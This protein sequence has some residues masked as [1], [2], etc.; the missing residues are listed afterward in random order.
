MCLASGERGALY[1]AARAVW[2]WWNRMEIDGDWM[3]KHRFQHE[4]DAKI[5]F[6]EVM[7]GGNHLALRTS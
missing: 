1:L 5:G 3:G 2:F 6:E 7:K 4:S